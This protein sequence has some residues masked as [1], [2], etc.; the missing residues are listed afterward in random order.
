MN[1]GPV[2]RLREDGVILRA[3]PAAER[4]FGRDEIRGESFRELCPGIP[5]AVWERI[6]TDDRPVQHE[7]EI[8]DL[9]Y[10]FTLVHEPE[11]NQVFVY[12]SDV[13]ELGSRFR[14]L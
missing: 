5:D 6:L 7:A 13:T 1:P 8:G 14:G 10:S 2:A 11:S 9:I 3:N 12:G 4:V